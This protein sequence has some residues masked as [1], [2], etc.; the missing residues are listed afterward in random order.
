MKKVLLIFAAALFL[1]S[2]SSLKTTVDFDKSVDFTKFKTYSYYGWAKDSDQI[3]SQF[4]KERIEKAL[5]HEFDVRDLQYV[6]EGG[7]L[8]VSL[9][10]VVNQE[11]STTA[12]TDH[13]GAGYG[14]Y[15]GYGP[16]WGWGGGMSTTTYQTYDYLVGTLVIDIFEVATKRLIWQGV[17]SKT[18]DDNPNNR[19]RN[20]PKVM[21]AIM[22][23][24]PVK[25][26]KK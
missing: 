26:V 2:C 15:Y 25:P 9:F 8:M 10:I 21:A 13:Y 1:V 3:L 11:T 4:D 16:G 20:V 12:Y 22:A 14:G 17:G 5:A 23:Q 6:K 19:D 24:Y 18:V 7:D